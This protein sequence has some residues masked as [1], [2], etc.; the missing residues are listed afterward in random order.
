MASISPFHIVNR[1]SHS[2]YQQVQSFRCTRVFNHLLPS[3]HE[4]QAYQSN[5]SGTRR[6]NRGN[7]YTP[8]FSLLFLKTIHISILKNFSRIDQMNS[9][10]SNQPTTRV[11]LLSRQNQVLIPQVVIIPLHMYQG[12]TMSSFKPHISSVLSQL[13]R[14]LKINYIGQKVN[15]GQHT[16]KLHHFCQNQDFEV[17]FITWSRVDHVSSRKI[18]IWSKVKV[19]KLGFLD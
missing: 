9:L 19:A 6:L 16:V 12:I 4:R 2:I 10:L 17:T 11:L 1:R 5:P 8:K 3:G 15:Y 18:K 7:C 13:L 14:W